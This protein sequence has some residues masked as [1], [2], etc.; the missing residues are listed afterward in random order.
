MEITNDHLKLLEKVYWQWQDAEYGAPEIDP[1][2]P[3]G[4]S[5]VENDIA[6]LLGWK[7]FETRDGEFE[8]SKE[9]A[10]KASELHHDLIEVI[11]QIIK[12]FT[13]A[14]RKSKGT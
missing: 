13:D 14:W 4:N 3:Y 12:E 7:I 11:P 2:R 8:L 6:E 10:D 9:Q 5:D 1:K